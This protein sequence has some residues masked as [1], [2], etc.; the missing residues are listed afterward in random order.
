MLGLGQNPADLPDTLDPVGAE[1]DAK[2]K[3]LAALA[4]L[5]QRA[6]FDRPPEALDLA[7][8]EAA[9]AVYQDARRPSSLPIRHALRRMLA[10]SPADLKT[11]AFR[12]VLWRLAERGFRLHPFDLPDLKS[13]LQ[14]GGMPLGPAE[15]TFL[16]LAQSFRPKAAPPSL[17]Q[18]I[19]AAPISPENWAQFPWLRASPLSR[20]TA[21]GTRTARAPLSRRALQPSPR[22]RALT[23]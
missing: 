23:S 18:A 20:R 9:L 15:P 22:P 13:E 12:I 5:G 4:L 7:Q 10:S 1:R 3:S 14:S 21:R 16:A 19:P 6:R 11:T 17:D 2:A 8:P